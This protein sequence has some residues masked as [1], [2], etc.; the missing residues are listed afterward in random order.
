MKVISSSLR[1]LIFMKRGI[2]PP[3]QARCRSVHMN[4]FTDST[5]QSFQNIKGI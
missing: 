3:D 2:F 1:D 4:E 5:Y